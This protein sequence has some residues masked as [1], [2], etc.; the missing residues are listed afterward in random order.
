MIAKTIG[1]VRKNFTFL[2]ASE[3]LV[4]AMMLVFTIVLARLY[5]TENFGIY[6]L[7]LSVGNLFEIIFNLG[8]GTVFMQRVSVHEHHADALEAMRRE[9]RVFLPLRVLLS[10]AGFVA[11]V[12]FAAALHKNTE[13][14]LTLVLAGLYFSLFSVEMFLWNCFDAR[15]EMHFTAA[16]KILKFTV[17]FGGGL[18]LALQKAPVHALMYAYIAGVAVAVAATVILIAKYFTRIGWHIDFS[19]W[20]KIIA[21]GW[22]ITLSGTFIFIYNSLDT[23]IISLV[24]GEHEVGLYQVSYKI[25]GTIFILATLINQAYLPSLIG[26]HGKKDGALERIFNNSLRSIFFWSVPIAAGGMILGE[27]IITYVFGPEYIAG[28]P[29]FRILVWNCVIFFLSSAMTNLLY[30]SKGQKKAVKIFFFGAL[31]NTLANIVMIPLY[32]II[33]AALT[34]VLAELVVLGGLY[35][36]ARRIVKIRLLKNTWQALLAVA[37]MSALLPFVSHESLIVTILAGALIYLGGY[38]LLQMLL[39]RFHRLPPVA[40]H[41][42]LPDGKGGVHPVKTDWPET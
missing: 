35:L 3:M 38:F 41:V 32:G 9:L 10:L 15:Q 42:L 17:I 6:A 11:M 16:A 19:A 21:E 37:V 7:A 24:K 18:W 1:T 4:R 40:D 13:T 8:L 20:K 27:R 36:L 30:A 23:I 26:A 39:R 29:A 5:G 33:G 22:P 25:T 31:A 14:F 2:F 34:T 12:V 28:V